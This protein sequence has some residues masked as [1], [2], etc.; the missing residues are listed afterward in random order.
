MAPVV[1][2]E[3]MRNS[4]LGLATAVILLAVFLLFQ[5]CVAAI[6][7][8]RRNRREPGLSRLIYCAVQSSSADA[9]D[10]RELGRFDRGL[11]RSMLLDLALD[12]K[13]DTSDAIA[14]LY[15]ELGFI[16]SDLKRLRSWR[17]TTRAHAA[18]D[19]GLIHSPE[20]MP[21]LADALND[22]DTRVRQAAVWAIGQVGTAAALA[23]LVPLLGDSSL[24]VAQRAQEVLASRGHE[25]AEAILSCAASTPCRA[26]RLAAIELIGWLRI[27]DG[28]DLMSV[29]MRDLD[30]EVRIKSVKAAA[31]IGDP[32]FLEPF[33]AL[34]DDQRWEVRCQAA[35][36]LSLFGSPS[37][38][39]RLRAALQDRH[40]WV[41]F[42]AAT[43]PAEVG[44]AG[45][46]ALAHALRDPDP[47]V[48]EMARYL[49]E[50]GTAVPALP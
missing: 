2:L 47:A 41:R 30:P 20:S 4:V 36:G 35:K 14:R 28:A 12:L 39:P 15:G 10:L 13:G 11:V 44:P 43:A 48:H 34:L 46:E 45:E 3:Q 25:V 31:A 18:A 49:L 5:R 7:A 40:W 37:S 16:R 8:A 32:R 29:C 21:A 6:A 26:A 24:P 42:Y 22:S 50:R 19:L 38:V 17:A 27:T 1:A 23:E 9:N 33:H